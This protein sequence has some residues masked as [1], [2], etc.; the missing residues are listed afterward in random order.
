MKN[1]FTVVMS[2]LGSI[3]L[4]LIIVGVISGS[5]GV[6]VALAAVTVSMWMV[7]TSAHVVRGQRTVPMRPVAAAKDNQNV[8]A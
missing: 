1:P 3:A 4:V 7:S 6:L 8:A 5:E 2:V